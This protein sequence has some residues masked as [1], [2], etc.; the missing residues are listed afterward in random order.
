MPDYTAH[1]ADS[2]S[3]T[4]H[5]MQRVM[6]GNTQEGCKHLATPPPELVNHPYK[7][8]FQLQP[9]VEPQPSQT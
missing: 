5:Q 3:T 1:A 9:L 6:P 2:T 8:A 4:L 7:R